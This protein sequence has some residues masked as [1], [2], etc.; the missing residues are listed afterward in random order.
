MKGSVSRDFNCNANNWYWAYYCFFFLLIQTFKGKI[1]LLARK[2]EKC[3]LLT[4]VNR[5]SGRSQSRE[6]PHPKMLLFSLK[7]VFLQAA[8]LWYTVW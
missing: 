8:I 1:I 5:V 3:L 4:R 6:C 7:T 2:A